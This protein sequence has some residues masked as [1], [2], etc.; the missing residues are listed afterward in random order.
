MN[1]EVQIKETALAMAFATE[2][3]EQ[4]WSRSAF[5]AFCAKRQITPQ[6][7]RQLWPR[8]LRSVARN[9]NEAADEQMC[10]AWAN[11]ARASLVDIVLRRFADNQ[12]LKPSVAR[13]AKSDLLHPFDTLT[14]TSQTAE[15]MLLCRGGYRNRTPVGRFVERWS[16]VVL[17]SVCVLVWIG[18]HTDGQLHTDRA[19]RRLLSTVGLG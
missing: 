4:G 17:Y 12:S 15:R 9:L 1:L 3:S 19:T 11:V 7:Q 13:L 10:L 8:G 14:R 2:A 16:L 6:Q 5:E 18:D